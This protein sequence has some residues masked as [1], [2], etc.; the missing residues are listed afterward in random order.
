MNV[1]TGY[2][3]IG[4][5]GCHPITN[6]DSYALDVLSTILGDWISITTGILLKI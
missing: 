6:K 4:F 1:E 3:L 2:I 5:K